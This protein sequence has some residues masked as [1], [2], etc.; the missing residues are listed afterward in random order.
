LRRRQ[1]IPTDRRIFL[2]VDNRRVI[3]RAHYLSA[4]LEFD[5]QAIVVDIEAQ[6]LTRREKVRAVDKK[7]NPAGR[8]EPERPKDT[9]L[10]KHYSYFLLSA[11]F[12]AR[13]QQRPSADA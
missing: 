7:C 6:R 2:I 8:K 5:E 13:P 11:P 9:K 4:A 3:E 12:R 10:T 1:S